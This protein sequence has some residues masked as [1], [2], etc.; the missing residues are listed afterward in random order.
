MID[1][2]CH[3]DL[4]ADKKELQQVLLDAETAGVQKIV[5]PGINEANW[6]RIRKL[7]TDY[8]QIHYALGFHPQFLDG[9]TK[10]SLERLAQLVEERVPEKCVAIGEC[11]L[12]FYHGREDEAFQKQVLEAQ[13][14]LAN[15]CKLPVLL[16]C[17]KAHQD[18]VVLLKQTQPKYG[19]VV[20]GFSGSLQ[21]A[22]D[23]VKLGLKIGVGGVITYERAKKTRAT[24]AAL[25]LESLLIETD[26]PDMPL[27]G[28]QGSPNEPKMISLVLSSLIELRNESEQT[29]ASQLDVN[30][31]STFNFCD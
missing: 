25:P 23:F 10:S 15:H 6:E 28:Y 24:I 27:S 3:L 11:G 12:D 9:V 22:M 5:V 2:H 19:G 20:H 4:L 7:S 13:I 8:D 17:R 30:S 29:V 16:H 21:Q 14:T 31:K 26:A 1:S 18:L